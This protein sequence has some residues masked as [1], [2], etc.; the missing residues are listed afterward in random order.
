MSQEKVDRYKEQKANRKELMK[1]AKRAEL[2]RNCIASVVLV[3]VIGWVGYSG[4]T[5]IIKHQ[6][7]PEVDV[8][9][10]AV[11]DYVE[12]LTAEEETTEDIATEETTTEDTASEEGITEDATEATE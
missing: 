12:T 11:A 10:T 3:A 6:P 2:I 4:V 8:N 1:K 5:Y 7:R 9:Y